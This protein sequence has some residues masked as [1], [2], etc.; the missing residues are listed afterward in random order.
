MKDRAVAVGPVVDAFVAFGAFDRVGLAYRAIL[1]VTTRPR[2]YSRKKSPSF[3][4]A[5]MWNSEVMEREVGF[6]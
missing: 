2:L 4:Q 1:P 5:P 3:D 6:R